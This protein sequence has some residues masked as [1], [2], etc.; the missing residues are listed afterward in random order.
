MTSP[1]VAALWPMDAVLEDQDACIA[2]M[3]ND[4]EADADA[5]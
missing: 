1:P 2:A 3:M 5:W 4:A